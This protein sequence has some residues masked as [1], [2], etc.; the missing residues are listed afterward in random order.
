MSGCATKFGVE[1]AAEAA[2]GPV[3]WISAALS[4]TAVGT[5]GGLYL[6][7]KI[8]DG[9]FDLGATFQSAKETAQN[10][11]VTAKAV[12]QKGA[13]AAKEAAQKGATAAKEAAQQSVT[14]AKEKAPAARV[15]IKK[16]AAA[17]KEA[18]LR[19]A[20]AVSGAGGSVIG[21][22]QEHLR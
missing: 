9:E 1:L 3:G 5:V 12:V 11:A 18:A 20:D 6:G 13:T 8:A 7:K 19:S 4:T 22:V 21:K 2:A 14:F 16:G 10:A 15:A 17:A